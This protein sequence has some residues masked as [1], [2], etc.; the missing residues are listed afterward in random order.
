MNSNEGIASRKEAWSQLRPSN[1]TEAFVYFRPALS[2]DGIQEEQALELT[3]EEAAELYNTCILPDMREAKIGLVWYVTDET[4]YNSVYD[5][6]IELNVTVQ[7]RERTPIDV[8]LHR[9][10]RVL[11]AHQRVAARSRRGAQHPG[12]NRLCLTWLNAV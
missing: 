4:Y 12:R 6:R 3:S 7:Q 5:C 8:F 9:A 10:D 2:E 1:V 11:G